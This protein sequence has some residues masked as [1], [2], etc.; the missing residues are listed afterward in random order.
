MANAD[1]KYSGHGANSGGLQMH[2]IGDEYPRMVIG[3]FAGYKAFNMVSG[4]Y[5]PER[6]SYKQ[7]K[8]DLKFD[9]MKAAVYAKI[10]A[11]SA[12][13]FGY[14]IYVSGAKV[15]NPYS[16]GSDGYGKFGAGFKDARSIEIMQE[17]AD[18]GYSNRGMVLQ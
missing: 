16:A 12:Y 2:S 3:S 6:K 4:S 13:A 7:A 9:A 18:Q 5:G 10:K 11:N 15:G 8:A 1:M 17:A 14:N